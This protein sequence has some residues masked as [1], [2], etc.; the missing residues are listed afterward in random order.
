MINVTPQ[1]QEKVLDVI[2]QNGPSLI[3]INE[4]ISGGG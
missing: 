1:A 2:R 4:E 3:R